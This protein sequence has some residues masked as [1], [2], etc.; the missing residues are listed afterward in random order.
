V[1]PAQLTA[2]AA[3]H[4][5]LEEATRWAF[6]QKPPLQLVDVVTQDEFT[7]DVILAAQSV[8]LVYDTT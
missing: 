6:S 2:V 7:H 8:Y 4:R 3:T 5:T 1:Q